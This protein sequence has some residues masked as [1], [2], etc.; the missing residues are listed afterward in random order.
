MHGIFEEAGHSAADDKDALLT[1]VGGR[2]DHSI[3]AFF[4]DRIDRMGNPNSEN[5]PTD[6]LETA[7]IMKKCGMTPSRVHVVLSELQASNGR[8]VTWTAGHLEHLLRATPTEQWQDGDQL[9]L[10]LEERQQKEGLK[11]Y[12][13][14]SML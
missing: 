14:T 12:Y 1:L 9:L 4:S 13:D 5:V 6:L 3:H 7:R 2:V 8:V 10:Y 11:Y